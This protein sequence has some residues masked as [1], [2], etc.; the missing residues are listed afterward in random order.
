MPR[1]QR[2]TKDQIITALTLY[3]N[4]QSTPKVVELL[5][6]PSVAMLPYLGAPFISIINF[7]ISLGRKDYV[8]VFVNSFPCRLLI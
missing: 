7:N 2:Y 1:G 3:N 8:N 4:L 6:Y 5:G